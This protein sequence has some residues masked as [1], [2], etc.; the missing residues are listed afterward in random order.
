MHAIQMEL[1]CRGYLAEPIGPVDETNW[2]PPFDDAHAAPMTAA[3]DQVLQA[4]VQFAAAT[5][6][7][8]VR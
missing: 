2:P 7:G 3:L 1:A 6:R 4:C 5:T 8:A